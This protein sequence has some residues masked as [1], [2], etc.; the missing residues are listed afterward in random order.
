MD[1]GWRFDASGNAGWSLSPDGRRLAIKLATEAGQHIWVKQLDDGPVSR[2]TFEGDAN[3]RPRWLPD[4]ETLSYVA[5]RADSAP[6]SL[7]TRRGDGTGPEARRLRIDKTLWEVV[8][9]R[10]GKWVVLRTGG[11]AGSTGD[12]DVYVMQIGVDTVPRPLLVTP[13]DE[14]A[15]ALS[16]DGR[17]LAYES[18]E[19][20]RDEVY[21]RPF[22]A[23]GDGKW[24]VSTSGGVAPLWS[25]TGT[26]LFFIELATGTLMSGRPVAGSFAAVERRPLFKGGS[27]FQM[28]ANYTPFDV[29]PDGRFLMV[30]SRSTSAAVRAP[31]ILVEN[32]F[33]ELKAKFPK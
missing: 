9:S 16:P 11:V 15:I 1:T 23:V 8:W 27:E 24:Q 10:D 33:E 29:A 22:P 12:R 26:E 14:K 31:L 17:W 20:G 25:R 6:Q 32:W 18:N 3:I 7:Y 13:P 4:G 30:R 19:T 2:V 5:T 21:V 28:S